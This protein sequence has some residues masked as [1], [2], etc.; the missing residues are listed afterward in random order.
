MARVKGKDTKPEK[1]VRAALFS[2]GL[3][4]RLQGSALPGR[5]DIVLK[6]RKIAIFVHGCFWHRHK[7]CASTRTPKSRQIWWEEKFKSNVA[8]D[9]RNIAAL[10]RLGWKV[11]IIWECETKDATKLERLVTKVKRLPKIADPKVK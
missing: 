2:S 4:Y 1:R 6:S 11:L 7:G 3:R 5:P 10:R 8:R 9:K